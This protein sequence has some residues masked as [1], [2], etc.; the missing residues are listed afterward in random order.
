MLVYYFL[1]VCGWFTGH[2]YRNII[3]LMSKKL[4]YSK[5]RHAE[6]FLIAMLGT[7]CLVEIC[8]PCTRVVHNEYTVRFKLH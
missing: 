2:L 4:V 6:Y 8:G 1:F 7:S 5:F 3:I